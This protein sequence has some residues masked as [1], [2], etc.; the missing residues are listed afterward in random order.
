MGEELLAKLQA[1][2]AT[3]TDEFAGIA[4]FCL[5]DLTTGMT[6]GHREDVVFPAASSIKIHILAALLAHCASA[7][8]QLDE[9]VHV[10][11]SAGIGGGGILGYL[12]HGVDLSLI[13]LGLLMIMLS[14][15]TATNMCIQ[16]AGGLERIND[17]CAEFGLRD[18]VM[19][20][21]M[22]DGDAIAEGRENVTTPRDM[23][24][25]LAQLHA[26]RPTKAIAE[27]CLDVMA[28]FKPS[29]FRAGLP[30]G[31]RLAHKTGRMAGVRNES[32]IVYLEGR[33]YAFTVMTAFCLVD[34]AE[35]DVYM[36]GMMR[37]A[38][39]VMHVLA[40]SNAYGQGRLR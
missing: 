12:H 29:P 10:D 23:I 26:G 14:D 22:R 1:D 37:Q 40:N 35:Q 11:P 18:T 27:Q 21:V 34:D 33:P 2:L 15:N 30:P 24:A 31:T 36:S 38:H 19:R 25:T 7:G 32:A 39:R 6:I 4:G 28:K 17:L 20:R 9:C 13:D 8:R 5:Q 3:R 16:A